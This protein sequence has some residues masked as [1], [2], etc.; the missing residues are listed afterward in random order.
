MNFGVL[1]AIPMVQWLFAFSYYMATLNIEKYQNPE[2]ESPKICGLSPKVWNKIL[3]WWIIIFPSMLF[4]F[5]LLFLINHNM[6]LNTMMEIC[7]FLSLLPLFVSFVVSVRAF[8][9]MEKMTKDSKFETNPCMIRLNLTAL[10]LLSLGG[11]LVT[12]ATI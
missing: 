9:L 11:F 7:S 6:V 8:R 2:F 10:F 1:T 5:S 3:I 12:I 4:L